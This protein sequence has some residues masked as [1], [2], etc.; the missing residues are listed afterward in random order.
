MEIIDVIQG[1]EEWFKCRAGIPTA[2]QFSKI[3]TTSGEISR[4]MRDLALNLASQVIV[5]ELEEMP[6]SYAMERGSELEFEAVEKYQTYTLNPVQTVGFM[7]CGDYGYSPDGLIGEDGILEIKCP[8]QKNHA[9]YLSKK[10][11][12][13]E[14]RAQVQGGLYVSDREWCDF[15]SYNPTFKTDYQMLVVRE[16]RDEEFIRSLGKA[17]KKCIEIRD[18]ILEKIKGEKK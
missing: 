8:L 18:E 6:T 13:S 9:K 1:S 14:Y 5:T 10:E 7:S 15:V 17:I 16:Y 4:S 2:S 12:P 3:V 11:V